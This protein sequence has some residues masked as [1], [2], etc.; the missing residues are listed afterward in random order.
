MKI[1]I[2]NSSD[3]PIY[4]QIVNEVKRQIISGEL[5]KDEALPGMRSLAKDLRVSVITTKRAYN[6]LEKD[7]FIYT[8]SGRGSY[9]SAIN[10]ASVKDD[11]IEKIKGLLKEVKT[12]ANSTGIRKNEVLKLYDEVENERAGN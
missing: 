1:I 3:V 9:V 7:G 4:E 2:L 5:K 12:I 6:D 8:I 11:G 10:Q